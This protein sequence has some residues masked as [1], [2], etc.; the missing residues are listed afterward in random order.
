MMGQIAERGGIVCG[1][2][3]LLFDDE[4]MAVVEAIARKTAVKPLAFAGET[5]ERA[6]A[7]VG[8]H[9]PVL[10]P[11]GGSLSAE[12]MHWGIEV[13]WSK[14]LV[15]NTRLESALGGSSMW[16]TPMQEGR[17]IVPAASFFETHATETISNPKTNR[18]LKR[19]YEFTRN[20]NEPLLLGGV[21]S[22]NHFSIVTTQPNSDV[23]SVH[24]RMPLVLDFQEIPLWLEGD[25]KE[26]AQL[27]D[28]ANISMTS[29]PD[30][31]QPGGSLNQDGDSGCQLSL[32]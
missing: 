2:I 27:A 23:V 3:T 12:N 15:F 16:K 25:L 30:A 10:A 1:R 11:L 7:R 5:R 9:A 19:A 14:K 24:P 29:K 18:P 13:P 26:I 28:R 17:C 22:G 4:L 20:D 32:F 6:Q 31:S 8:G 21:S